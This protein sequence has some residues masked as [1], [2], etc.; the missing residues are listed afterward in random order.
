MVGA[1]GGGNARDVVPGG[2]ARADRH[3]R[4]DPGAADEMVAKVL[5]LK[6]HE[7]GITVTIARGM[8]RP[9][10]REDER[11][12]EPVRAGE[13]LAGQIAMRS[14]TS[15]PAAARTGLRPRRL[16]DARRA[17]RPNSL[18]ANPRIVHRTRS[19]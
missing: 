9:H 11:H 7:D 6:S 3:A 2:R 5:A 18:R 12:H 4:L 10:L 16:R 8:N 17:R 15:R 1:I 19:F 14:K 13:G